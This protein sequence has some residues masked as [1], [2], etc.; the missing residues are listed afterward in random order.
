MLTYSRPSARVTARSA[1]P[2]KVATSTRRCAC[3]GKVGPGGECSRCRSRRLAAG[4]GRP[5]GASLL[6]SSLTRPGRALDA[7]LR[8]MY[9]RSFGRDLGNVQVH[10]DAAAAAAARAVGA[11][12]FTVGRNIAFG[13]SE[14][15]P[16][17]ESGRRLLA[18]ELAH[19]IQQGASTTRDP[20]MVQ[21]QADPA[22]SPEDVEEE[23]SGEV[24]L[25]VGPSTDES[26]TEE[27]DAFLGP[28]MQM[29]P[30][31][32]GARGDALE[33]EADAAAEA[34]VSGRTVAITGRMTA[35]IRLARKPAPKK[36][37]PPQICG[38]PSRR[39]ADFPQTFISEISVDVTSPNHSVRLVWK[40]PSAASGALGPFHSS[41]GAGN[42]G[43]NCNNVKTSQTVGTRCTPKGGSWPVNVTA[44]EMSD[45]PGAKN[46]TYF[47]RL[48]IALHYY[49]S[50]PNWPASHG[51][52]RLESLYV[53]QLI[54][55]NVIAGTTAVNVSGTW[56]RG[57]DPRSGRPVCW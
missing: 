16:H 50:V 27:W 54:H 3:G 26:S 11:R 13:S 1:T 40:G 6:R 31:Q 33:A 24:E 55:D 39:M 14:Y 53:S 4:P 38:R 2:D 23:P 34:V 7:D 43:L 5:S 51:C 20:V 44:C 22:M 29:T 57:T 41:P 36:T 12:A 32:A 21:R 28:S 18:H 25:D 47:Q 17:E 45:S 10:D 35:P 49:P 19:V 46:V 56:T 9:E 48:G 37:G 30:L 8:R 15:R 42:C 52:V